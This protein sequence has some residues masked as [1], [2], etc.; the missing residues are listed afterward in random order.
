[1][2]WIPSGFI[3]KQTKAVHSFLIFLVG[4]WEHIVK[5]YVVVYIPDFG[6]YGFVLY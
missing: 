2:P 5:S 3:E 6:S 4:R 1:M